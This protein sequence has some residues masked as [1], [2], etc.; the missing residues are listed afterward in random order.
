MV[1]LLFL[2][3]SCSSEK[4]APKAKSIQEI[5]AEVNLSDYQEYNTSLLVGNK[6]VIKEEITRATLEEYYIIQFIGPIQNSWKEYLKEYGVVF[7]DYIPQ[8]AFKVQLDPVKLEEVRRFSFVKSITLYKPAYKISSDVKEKITT[9]SEN[10]K[11]VINV[12]LHNKKDA[13]NIAQKLGKDVLLVDGDVITINATK[14]TIEQILQEPEISY[15]NEVPELTLYNDRARGVLEVPPVFEDLWL[16]G[17]GEVIG[18]LDSGLDT[19]TVETLHADVRG[20][21]IEVSLINGCNGC[22]SPDDENGHGTH[23]A[24]SAVGNGTKSDGLYKG[25]APQAKLLFTAMGMDSGGLSLSNPG[26]LQT[27]FNNAYTKDARIHSNSWG[28]TFPDGSYNELSQKVDNFMWNNK[29]MLI[30]FAAGNGGSGENT[31]GYP[32]TAKNT[33]TIGSVF[34]KGDGSSDTVVSSSSRG[35]TDDGRIKPDLV[36]PGHY[37]VSTKSSLTGSGFYTTI[38]GTSMATPLAA[39]VGALVRQDL[40]VNQ[41]V[42]QPSAALVKALLI[43]GAVQLSGHTFPSNTSGWG[44]INL[45]NTLLPPGNTYVKYI[46]ETTGAQTGQEIEYRFNVAS[47]KP[48]KI[49]L[50][51][52]DAPPSSVNNN[53]LLVNDLNLEIISPSGV[54][55]NGNDFNSPYHDV[56]DAKNTVE[57]VAINT[58]EQGAYIV[59][60]KGFN[61]PQGPQPFALVVRGILYVLPA[62]TGFDG[63]TTV[64]ETVA[65]L[66]KVQNLTLEKTSLGKITW[67]N[68]VYVL[69]QN[70]SKDVI[71]QENFVSVDTNLLHSSFNKSAMIV[72][73]NI[74]VIIPKILKDG[75][76]CSDCVLKNYS[77]NKVAFSVA[78][79]SNYSI[80]EGATSTLEVWDSADDKPFGN[81]TVYQFKDATIFANYT[82][83]T[84]GSPVVNG[85]CKLNINSTVD[86]IFNQTTSLYEYTDIFNQGGVVTY[87]VTC[88][89][90][91]FDTLNADGSITV[92]DS[93]IFTPHAPENLSIKK[94]ENNS[95]ALSWNP[96]P[97]A[98]FY[99]VYFDENV[100]VLLQ[101]DPL[102]ESADITMFS[103]TIYVDND[104]TPQRY[105]TVVAVNGTNKNQSSVVVGRFDLAI[106]K[107]QTIV[108]LHLIVDNLS[109]TEVFN[110]G[111]DNDIVYTY[112]TNF[113]KTLSNQYIDGK[114]YGDFDTLEYGKAYVFKPTMDY[115]ITLAG[116]VPIG[117][118]TMDLFKSTEIPGLNREVNLVGWF[119]SQK[120]CGFSILLSKAQENDSV[121]SYDTVAKAYKSSVKQSNGSWIGTL[122]CFVPG[123]GYEFRKVG[124]NYIFEYER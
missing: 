53:P 46:D 52:T 15:V 117:N 106:T 79:F 83:R 61:I 13:K 122:D 116:T 21:V 48:L 4:N 75:M 12:F 32:G 103:D 91:Q 100:T 47:D 42:S 68:P 8:Y 99:D 67:D 89:H 57:Q 113:N 37:V 59:K 16:D 51:W 120:K 18:I 58:S 78:G 65:D 64:F 112:D 28:H 45:T 104:L 26:Q 1:L 90:P 35:P 86:M 88:S 17:E 24:G 87:N 102:K 60:V 74:S 81:K 49:T 31:V 63:A 92:L 69:D 82:N 77:K 62:V 54:V 121:F 71:I 107:P 40:I 41:K 111:Y 19:G 7:Y 94:T 6:E 14:E 44:R 76:S 34:N 115:N 39:G 101:L 36:A 72:L 5:N 50:V 73:E 105:Y 29:D 118:F 85:T 27:T 30:Y 109:I 11:T 25:T 33:L 119:N 23:V 98:V 2:L 108:S 70:L 84:D 114:W 9:I 3:A 20:R 55:Y 10:E 56:F 124:E 95:I 38:G 66:K 43:N 96:V 123:K 110:K 80:I 22:S 93:I 97:D